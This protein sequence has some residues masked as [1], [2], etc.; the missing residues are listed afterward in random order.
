MGSFNHKTAEQVEQ[1]KVESKRDSMKL[2]RRKFKIGISLY[3]IDGE[4]LKTKIEG[5]LESLTEPHK[6]IAQVSYED[7]TQFDRTDEMV[8]LLAQEIGLTEEQVDDFY[9]WAMNEG[10]KNN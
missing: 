9:E 10:W 6:T 5:A 2:S 4:T 3:D 1:E 8:Q 7:G